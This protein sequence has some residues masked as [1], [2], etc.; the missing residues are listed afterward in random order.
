MHVFA[1]RKIKYK[2]DG[3]DYVSPL[4]YI[5]IHMTFSVLHAWISYFMM[6]NFFQSLTIIVKKLPF[7]L[8][9]IEVFAIIALTLIL[10]EMCIYLAYFKDI[11]FS[12]VTLVNYIGLLLF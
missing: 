11:I 3:R 7:N 4:E 10:I 12:L 9:P 2:D 8:I 6:F 1:Y 5:S